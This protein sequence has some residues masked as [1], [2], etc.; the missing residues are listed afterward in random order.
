MWRWRRSRRPISAMP[1][2]NAESFRLRHRRRGLGR[3]RA[4]QPAQRRRPEPR[5]PARIWR[6][7]PLG[8]HPDAGGAVDPDEQSPLRMGLCDRARAASERPDPAD[9]ARQGA[10]RLVLDQR[11]RLC[12][13]QSARL[14]PLAGGGRGRLG[15]SRRAALFQARRDAGRGRRPL[16]RRQRAAADAE[17]PA[18]Q[19]ALPDIREGR[20]RGRLSGLRRPQRLPAGRFRRRST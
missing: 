18:R 5:A 15:L 20:R 7:R 14:R 17:R 8:L 13:R 9:A 3:L 6:Q 2:D 4:R 12:A 19:S 11:P 10:R 16:S 1:T